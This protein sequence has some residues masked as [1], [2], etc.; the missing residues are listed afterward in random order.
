[1]TKMQA[2]YFAFVDVV[3]FLCFVRYLFLCI[4]MSAPQAGMINVSPPHFESQLAALKK[5]GYHTL[6]A[7]E[8]ADY[9]QGK[10]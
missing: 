2:R 10:D 6:K 3:W 9:L 4:T 8:F 5:A 7:S 1:M